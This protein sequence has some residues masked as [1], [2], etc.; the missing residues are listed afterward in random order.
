[1]VDRARKKIYS[2]P[3]LNGLFSVP[4]PPLRTRERR[5][6]F[7]QLLAWQEFTT[8]N[9]ACRRREAFLDTWTGAKRY[10][11][12][13]L[14]RHVRKANEPFPHSHGGRIET[15]ELIGTD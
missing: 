6:F 9:T 7:T 11:E 5:G 8:A 10:N 1:M 15:L 4:A 3:Y 12:L 13:S 14:F 2:L